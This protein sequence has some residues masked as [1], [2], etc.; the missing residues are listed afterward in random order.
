MK[1]DLVR[2]ARLAGLRAL[3]Y[4]IV[5]ALLVIKFSK[6]AKL[7]TKYKVVLVTFGAI[8]V[9]RNFMKHKLD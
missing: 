8:L 3:R 9:V 1:L 5:G 7:L 4:K 2:L 6:L